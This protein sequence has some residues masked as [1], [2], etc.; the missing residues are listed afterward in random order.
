MVGRAGMPQDEGVTRVRLPLRFV[1]TPRA[2]HTRRDANPGR[3]LPSGPMGTRHIVYMGLSDL[4][5]AVR[6]PKNHDLQSIAN[7]LTRYG[8]TSPAEVDERTGRLV[9]GHGRREACIMLRQAGDPPPGGVFIDDDGEWLVPV[10]R[11]WQ[12]RDDAEAEAYI[13]ASNFLTSAGGWYERG[14]AEMLEDVVT[15]DAPL[16]ET[17]GMTFETVDELIAKF[18]PE[19]LNQPDS[20]EDTP[21]SG[22]APDPDPHMDLSDGDESVT[23]DDDREPAAGQRKIVCPNCNHEWSD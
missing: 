10:L 5:P 6:N 15:A 18:D 3:F 2:S 1:T 19:T 7:S 21:G 11:G 22:G 4:K 8:W 13:I 16:I 9:A 12:S 20:D 14:L 17:T 23:A